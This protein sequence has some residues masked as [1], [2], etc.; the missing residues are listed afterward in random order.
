MVEFAAAC[1][2][3]IAPLSIVKHT[4]ASGRQQDA[5]RKIVNSHGFLLPH[6][7]AQC[8]PSLRAHEQVKNRLKC[9]LA[10]AAAVVKGVY[11]RKCCDP[12]ET[13]RWNSVPRIIGCHSTE[14]FF[15]C[16]RT[17]T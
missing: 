11:L 7:T 5:V 8:V 3:L 6:T 1:A 9:A 10:A 13:C 16:C 4:L 2:T 17:T 14:L 12:V 15:R